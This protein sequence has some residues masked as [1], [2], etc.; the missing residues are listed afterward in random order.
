ML[1]YITMISCV[2][3][4]LHPAKDH[5]RKGFPKNLFTKGPDKGRTPWFL[6]N[7]KR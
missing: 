7:H 6:H 3:I 5:P 4:I 1:Q 2:L